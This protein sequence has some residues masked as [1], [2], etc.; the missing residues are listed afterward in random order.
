MNK[1]I[2]EPVKQI[3]TEFNYF[4]I[5]CNM[6]NQICTYKSK[7]FEQIEANMKKYFLL[8]IMSVMLT[9]CG[10]FFPETLSVT[11]NCSEHITVNIR[12]YPITLN[13]ESRGYYYTLDLDIG[14]T[15]SVEIYSNGDIDVTVKAINSKTTATLS[16]YGI[17]KDIIVT[18]ADFEN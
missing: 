5:D 9:K 10:E 7:N 12:F 6:T 18:D 14:E 2:F 13:E 17:G 8:F 11:N 4:N 15:D 3:H 1:S 16:Y